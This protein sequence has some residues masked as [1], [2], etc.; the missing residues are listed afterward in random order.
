[1]F[2]IQAGRSF[3]GPGEPFAHMG[4]GENMS[5]TIE[6]LETIGRDASLR[7]AGGYALAQALD[8]LGAGDGLKRAAA[9]GDRDHLVQEF[10]DEK[11]KVNQNVHDGGCEPGEGDAEEAPDRDDG[12]DPPGH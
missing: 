5:S 2:F 3:P 12:K 6:L 8:G 10:G 1:M 11:V 7:H 4:T 9:S